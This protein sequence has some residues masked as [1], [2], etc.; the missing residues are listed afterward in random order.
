M[1]TLQ[2][3]QVRMILLTLQK[4][5]VTAYLHVPWCTEKVIKTEKDLHLKGT[6]PAPLT[7]RLIERL[8]EHMDVRFL[9]RVSVTYYQHS[10]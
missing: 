10:Q 9:P 7:Q 6:T 2:D 3:G 1:H 5:P 4:P 8:K